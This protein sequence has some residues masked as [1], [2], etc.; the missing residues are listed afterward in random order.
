MTVSKAQPDILIGKEYSPQRHPSAWLRTDPS[1]SSG[2]ATYTDGKAG[3]VECFSYL[4]ALGVSAV[5]SPD[6][7]LPQRRR[8]K[9]IKS[10]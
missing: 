9:R 8:E 7:S 10:Y 2:Q 6:E 3:F 1:A 5:K 4:W